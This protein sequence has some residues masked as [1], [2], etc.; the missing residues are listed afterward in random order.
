M[1]L[2]NQPTIKVVALCQNIKMLAA[3]GIGEGVSQ[4]MCLV[5]TVVWAVC[6]PRINPPLVS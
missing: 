6:E 5:F 1:L 4:K 2:A 3:L